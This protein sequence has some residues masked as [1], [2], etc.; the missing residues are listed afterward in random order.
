MELPVT[1]HAE[2]RDPPHEPV[3]HPRLRN[4]VRTDPS[5]IFDEIR[6]GDILVHLPY[7]SFVARRIGRAC[8]VA[9]AIGDRRP[10]R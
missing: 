5:A 3:T 1:G 9:V 10:R 7:H 8:G 4:L 2:Q 6:R